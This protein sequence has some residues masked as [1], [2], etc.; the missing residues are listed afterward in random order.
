[1]LGPRPKSFLNQLRIM[2]GQAAEASQ[3]ERFGHRHR[4]R[5]LLK[6]E[7]LEARR[8]FAVN[9][10]LSGFQ[11]LIEGDNQSNGISVETANAGAPW[12]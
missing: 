1:M 10:S 11:L 12:W 2:L 5:R 3:F 8:P 4:E 7:S 9:V 6:V